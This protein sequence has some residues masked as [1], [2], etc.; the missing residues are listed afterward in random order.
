MCFN[1]VAA[2]CRITTGQGYTFTTTFLEN[3]L[4]VLLHFLGIVSIDKLHYFHEVIAFLDN[5]SHEN[6]KKAI[7]QLP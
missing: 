3:S 4:S 5:G 1:P 6:R 7:F 2:V